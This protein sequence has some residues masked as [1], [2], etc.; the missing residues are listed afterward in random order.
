MQVIAH[1]IL[2]QFTDRQL[3]MTGK[4]RVKSTEKLS[5]GYRVNRAA[6]DAAGLSITEKM[7]YQIRG[8]KRGQ[9]NIQD[10]SSWLQ[11]ADGSMEEIGKIIHRIRELSVQASNDTNTPADRAA[12]DNEVSQLKHEI[13]EIS[14]NAEFNTQDIFDNSYVSMDVFGMPND[15]QVFDATYDSAT[16]NVTYGGFVFQGERYTWDKVAPGMVN[17]DPTTGK[18][19]FKGGDY[20]YKDVNGN[21]FNISC[22]DGDEVPV[23]SRT[24]EFSA[25]AQGIVIDG[26]TMDWSNVID[27]D[28]NSFSADNIH[29]GAWSLE[30][31]GATLAFFVGDVRTKD[32]MIDSINSCN[33][34]KVS[35]T[36]KTEFTG[37][38]DVKAVDAQVIK[39]LQISNSFAANLS[40]NSDFS[41]TV[42]A[43]KSGGQ[44]G[45]WL[46][47]SD[48]TAVNGSFKSWADLGIDS[49]DSGS[50]ISSQTTYTYSDDEGV[51]DTYI[52]FEFSL[53]DITSVDSVIDGLDGMV[54]CGQNIR[55][56]YSTDVDAKLDGNIQKVTSTV[57]NPIFFEEEKALGRDFDQQK[58]DA[59]QK[60]DIEYDETSKNASLKFKDPSGNTVLEYTTET[61]TN[62]SRL[63]RDLKTYAAYVLREKQK[64]ALSGKDPQSSDVK[65]GSGSL[66]DLVGAGNITTSGHFSETVTIKAGMDL[67]DGSGYFHPG[68]LGKTYPAA[69]IDFSGL[70][71]AYTLDSLL[72]LGFNSTCKTCDNHY[73]VLFTDGSADSVSANGHQ[74]S[75][76]KQGDKDYLLQID[77][78][79]LK[80]NGVS[81][82]ADLAKAIVDI[83]TDCFDFH[84]TQ[85]GAEGDKLWVYDNREQNSGTRDATFDTAP[86]YSIDTDVFDFSLKT[87]DGE[88]S[89]DVSY[90]YNYGSIAD[91]IIVEMQQ[92][93]QGDYVKDANG[94]YVLYDNA[95]P[96]HAGLDRYEMKL[97]YKNADKSQNVND[98][99]E[100]IDSYKQFAMEEMLE[101]T[102]VQ[103]NA[104][105][106]TYMDMA[107]DEN[108]NVAIK[109]VFDS[110]LEE[111][112]IENGLNIQASSMSRDRLTIP[113]FPMNTVVL[114]LYRAGTKTY[115]QA[116]DSINF[117]DN[118]LE[119]LLDKRG[120][121]GAY[122]NRLEYT[123][124]IK[125]IEEEN[126]QAAES[127]IRDTDMAE[128][129][130]NLSKHNI[131]LQSGQSMLAQ[132]NHSMDGILNLL[133]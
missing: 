67:S 69:S 46:E 23:I 104:E 112:P 108:S 37:T 80:A 17:I 1:N 12:I 95:N 51:N 88:R 41:Y 26:K 74:Y 59:F 39:N 5:S 81:S 114:R 27:E 35:Y 78:N 83:T 65:L 117:C 4:E 105:D 82:G 56:N 79:S 98:L 19:V 75:F 60:E 131:L 87:Q 25:T 2:S 120:L 93:A 72:G 101:K 8:L 9:I 76:Q 15:L 45:I 84:Y 92:T 64:L 36:W 119:K 20:S 66:T 58:I 94:S 127:R 10:G 30:Y 49:W 44:N 57:K 70:G 129:M 7:R 121:Y 6:D 53:S 130:L 24:L 116:Q 89:I 85:Y 68:D 61:T 97:S 125:A 22:K 34:G 77:I 90:T 115:Q 107:G 113:R 11:V 43:G 133:Q 124:S 109:A 91:S 99:N 106:Y 42:R 110:K 102:S 31:Q 54:I 132:S 62:E 16:G 48:G 103:L 28:G 86:L 21:Y 14:R 32:D 40:S 122:M 13:N 73:S 47:N 52:S 18:Q 29:G 63:D 3:N 126:V 100:A 55:T 118:A 128:E 71:T 50:S 96:S 123:N 111:T 38:Q 33:N